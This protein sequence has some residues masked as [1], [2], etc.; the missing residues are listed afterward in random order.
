MPKH[1]RDF[2]LEDIPLDEA[3]KRQEMALREV[4]KW[5]AMPAERVSLPEALGRVT[6]EPVWA[7]IS[8]PHYHAAAMDGYA[9]Q[10]SDTL[11]ATETRPIRLHLD[12]QV[13]GVDTG[14][15]LPP[16]TN[17]VIMI[18]DVQQSQTG[19]I[20]IRASVAPWQHIRLMGEDIAA[21]ELVLPINHRIRPV[22][23][24]AL[25]G[26]GHHAVPVRRRPHVVIIPTGDELIPYDQP[27]QPGQ[28]IE[29]NSL[30]LSAQ[31][32]NM[33]GKWSIERIVPD[34]P[35]RLQSMLQE[36]LQQHPD[37]ILMLSG[38]SAGSQDYTAS[39]I[40]EMGEL[41]VHGV[42]V[43]PGHPVIIGMVAQ[44]PIIGI[45]GYPVS[46]ALT[47][48]LFVQPLLAHWL[49]IQPMHD[50]LPR[51]Q[52]TMTR[53]LASPMGDDDFVRVTVAQVSERILATP[54]NRGAGVITSL[55]RADGLAHI[56]RFSEGV[57]IGGAVEVMLYQSIESIR[58][59]VLMM[60]SHDPMIDLLGQ[61]LAT[62]FPGH[63]LAS[64]HVG[65]MGGLVALRRGEAHVAGIH[66][67]DPETGDFNI[68][69]VRNHL[70]NMKVQMMTF[71]HREQGF[72]IAPG[73][74]LH[75]QSFDDL[76]RVRYVNRQRGAGTRVL[77]DY[78]LQRRGISP[79]SI[80]GYEHEE[81]THLAVASA[82]ASGI[83][84]CGLGVRSSAIAMKLDFVPVSW[85]RYDL[86]F[87]EAHLHHPGVVHLHEIVRSA[88]FQQALA[89]QPG[90]DTRVTGHRQL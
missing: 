50:L 34:N 20:E 66:L 31:V 16:G 60:G 55:V 72:I 2:Y 39:I 89:E 10:A 15:P 68:V 3:R 26:C 49:G 8:S 87:P 27:V 52:A 22:D 1:E 53:K 61:F 12:E 5:E 18:E 80:V 25:A 17:A 62:Q 13:F 35:Q 41:L 48:E 30:V 65:S 64:N 28:I 47:G 9:V 63:R 23:L 33:G 78:E 69:Y 58:Q 90:Y 70:P 7:K 83:A 73:N 71:A 76:P 56:P 74:P 57:D 40:R 79:E 14:D 44:T 46:A 29:Y 86:V 38:S 54:L 82:V 32:T 4:G 6:A 77:L 36:A 81:Y 11:N 43:R 37:L 45:P 88:S 19:F 67:L 21:T 84:D 59:T 42:A 85:E 75:I 24:G 51:V